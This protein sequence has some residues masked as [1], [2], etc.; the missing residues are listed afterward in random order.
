MLAITG[1][2]P[3]LTRITA[4][5]TFLKPRSL[6]TQSEA[7]RRQCFSATASMYETADKLL[8]HLART[9]DPDYLNGLLTVSDG[10][11]SNVKAEVCALNLFR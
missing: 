1:P 10:D 6:C 8:P 4:F 11:P 9:F 2:R 7:N 3:A 5:G